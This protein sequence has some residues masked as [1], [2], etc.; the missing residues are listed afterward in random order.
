MISRKRISDTISDDI[1]KKIFSE[2]SYDNSVIGIGS[3][4]PKV[5]VP[6]ELIIGDGDSNK[7]DI[8]I[9]LKNR[10]KDRDLFKVSRLTFQS[11]FDLVVLHI[12][13]VD[14]RPKCSFPGCGNYLKWS[15]R[16]IWGYGNSQEE[17]DP[18]NNHFCNHSCSCKNSVENGKTG[19]GTLM[20]QIS[21]QRSQFIIGGDISDKCYFYIGIAEYGKFKFGVCTNPSS[22]FGFNRFTNYRILS[23]GTRIQM[24]NLEYWVKYFMGSHKEYLD[25]RPSM[26]LFRKSYHKSIGMINIDPK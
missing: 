2:R 10:F 1:L 12:K 19:F 18:N 6:K 3:K 16:F 13:Y 20:N 21:S 4:G 26:E 24:A 14:E 5:I 17:W 15:G 9:S 11:L 22:R 8:P 25:Y 7:N 23:E